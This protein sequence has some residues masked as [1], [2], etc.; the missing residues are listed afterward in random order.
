[1]R[2]LKRDVTVEVGYFPDQRYPDGT[3][4]AHV[5]AANEY[6]FGPWT[7]RPFFRRAVRASDSEM[8]RAVR[9]K[10]NTRLLDPT[11]GL[12]AAGRALQRSVSASI[13]QFRDPDGSNALVVTGRMRDSVDVRT[14]ED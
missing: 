14:R 5:A 9:A 13:E 10:T 4:V 6:G 7:E 1:M 3:P 2:R 8:R 12:E 11:P